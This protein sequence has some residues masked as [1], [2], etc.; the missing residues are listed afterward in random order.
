MAS[1]RR[2][3]ASR[4]SSDRETQDRP[5]RRGGGRASRSSVRRPSSSGPPAGLMIAG[6][7]LGV[8]VL[9]WAFMSGQGAAS[10]ATMIFAAE[11]AFANGMSTNDVESKLRLAE[12]D[13]GLSVEE[14]NRIAKLREQLKE[15]D[16]QS[17]LDLH[18]NVG[19]EYAQTKLRNYVDRYLSEEVEAPK[20][21]VFLER[22]EVFRDRWPEHPELDWVG[23]QERRLASVAD[24]S[25]PPTWE[26][27]AWKAEALTWAKPRDY[28]LAF[29]AIDDFVAEHADE[30]E[31]VIAGNRKKAMIADRAEYHVDRMLQA[32]FELKENKD[33][34][35]AI[36]WL[37]HGVIGMGDATMS[38]EAAEAL[39]KMPS[40]DAY[41]RGYR[42]N[43]ALVF[44]RLLQNG[45][46][47]AYIEAN[48]I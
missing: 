32:E 10:G 28:A 46:V 37:V 2:K 43:Q 41:L 11:K 18:N 26:D 29:A 1:A 35:A 22:A 12:E 27:V 40:C 47:A 21:R 17:A 19:T 24:L 13:S 9:G 25:K 23:R 42:S 8:G 7:V 30:E 4:R 16:A 14:R 39:L 33:E 20:A 45:K 6:V 31:K 48:E 44:E 36:H 5:A 15:R 3:G 34:G 38:D